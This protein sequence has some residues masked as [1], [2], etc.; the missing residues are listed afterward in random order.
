MADV[1]N[2]RQARKRKARADAAREAAGNRA[3]FGRTR[4][5]TERDAAEDAEARRRLDQLRRDIPEGEE[6]E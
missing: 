3:K 1:I 4:A 5:Q 2:L 6:K